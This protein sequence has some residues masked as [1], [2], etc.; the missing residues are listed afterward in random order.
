MSRKRRRRTRI[1]PGA[2]PGTLQVDRAARKPRVRIMAFGP[3]RCEER[4]V[5]RTEEIR[6]IMGKYP[7]LWVNVDGLGDEATLTGLSSLFGLHGLALEDVVSLGQRAK[8]EQYEEHLFIV[9]RMATGEEPDAS[10]QVSLFLGG[11]FVLTFQ[12]E[13]TGDCFDPV[14]ERIRNG[15]GLLR[16]SGPDYLAY[17]L[18]DA[19]IDAHFPEVEKID[20]A[21]EALEREAL[22]EPTQALVVAI[23]QQKARLREIRR[24]VTAHRD[25]AGLLLHEGIPF[26]TQSTQIYLRDCLDH[27]I[28]LTELVDSA[29]EGATEL[30]NVYL[31]RATH[32]LNEV[33]QMLT[34]VT[35]IFIPLSFITGI[36]GMN[37]DAQRSP[38]NM[39][40][41][42]WR[43]GYPAA[44]ALMAA[45]GGG[46]VLYFRKKKWM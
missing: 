17:A 35:S 19:V 21:L 28:R 33:M 40:E 3:D 29:R 6:A 45:V 9:L 39:P 11:G 38:W 25:V 2:S 18:I 42:G 20:D 32:R 41:L 30:M 12:E 23:Q 14:R 16:R 8:V 22:A 44:L 34:I 1:T 13:T 36:Y 27:A 7:V 46:M 5:S 31:S 4:D 37:F 15:K 24:L 10:E 26:I 43:W